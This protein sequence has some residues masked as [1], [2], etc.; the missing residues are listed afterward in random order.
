M[1]RKG[2]AF[3]LVVIFLI[4]VSAGA[5]KKCFL[6]NCIMF[7]VPKTSTESLFLKKHMNK[8]CVLFFVTEKQGLKIIALS[9]PKHVLFDTPSQSPQLNT[10]KCIFHVIK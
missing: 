8:S 1:Q 7:H 9:T 3:M 5:W 2:Y 4:W 6:K 10:W